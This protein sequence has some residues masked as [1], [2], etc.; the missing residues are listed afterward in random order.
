MGE[1]QQQAGN[2]GEYRITEQVDGMSHFFTIAFDHR[3]QF[4]DILRCDLSLDK[5][6]QAISNRQH[7]D[8]KIKIDIHK[9]I[10]LTQLNAEQYK[11]SK[12]VSVD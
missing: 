6:I 5:A 4:F 8:N 3:L 2:N 1:Q 11:K 9:P 10:I 12:M 7:P